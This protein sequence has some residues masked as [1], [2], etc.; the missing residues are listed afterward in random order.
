[1]YRREKACVSNITS[2]IE[3]SKGYSI[4]RAGNS[5][6]MPRKSNILWNVKAFSCCPLRQD[7]SPFSFQLSLMYPYYVI[8]RS[9]MS[10]IQIQHRLKESSRCFLVISFR[11]NK[12][13]LNCL[14]NF[15]IRNKKRFEK[16]I[17]QGGSTTVHKII[18]KP[19]KRSSRKI[20]STDH[21]QLSQEK[22]CFETSISIGGS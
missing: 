10:C 6:E 14:R 12:H 8:P 7:T 2:S 9:K 11:F 21:L 3:S 18:Q 1:M 17:S 15:I 4:L 19:C 5:E 13:I 22:D 16:N 20:F